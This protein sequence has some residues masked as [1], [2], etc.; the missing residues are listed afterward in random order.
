MYGLTS[1]RNTRE[2]GKKEK[3]DGW[4]RGVLAFGKRLVAHKSAL[5]K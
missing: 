5:L 1:D 2:R 3:S 4:L